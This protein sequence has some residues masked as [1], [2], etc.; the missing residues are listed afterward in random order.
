[1]RALRTRLDATGDGAVIHAR[2]RW[3]LTGE[4][5]SRRE[6][7]P[8]LDGSRRFVTSLAATQAL[9][10][11][12]EMALAA[13]TQPVARH[14]VRR[15]LQDAADHGTLRPLLCASPALH[16]YLETRRGSFGVH[17]RS[18]TASWPWPGR[19]APRPCGVSRTGEREVL[20]LLPS[21]R[22]VDEIADDL[23]VSANTVKTRQAGDLPEARRGQPARRGRAG[24]PGRSARRVGVS[25]P[26]GGALRP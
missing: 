10:L 13:G 18:S 20:E 22:S 1:M 6:L 3:A 23:A 19:R 8:A 5:G 7:A 15:A 26:A 14:R 16:D 2:H 12:A 4:S 24:P 9:V 11:D 25:R 17:D 21:M